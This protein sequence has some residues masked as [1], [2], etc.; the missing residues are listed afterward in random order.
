MLAANDRKDM[1]LGFIPVI[2]EAGRITLEVR[3]GGMRVDSKADDSPVSEADLRSQAHIAEGLARLCPDI[4]VLS[5]EGDHDLGQIG[6]RYFLVDPLDGTKEFVSGRADFAINIA[7]IEDGRPTVGLLYAPARKYLYLSWG[8]RT[9]VGK[10][11]G[12]KDLA[13]LPIHPVKPRPPVVLT[14]RS[15]LDADTKAFLAKL[16]EHT[17]HPMGSALK[18]GLV[19]DG[20][21]D[22]YPRF[23]P[24]MLWDV[25]AGQAVIEAAGGVVVGLDGTPLRYDPRRNLRN[26]SFIAARTPEAASQALRTMGASLQ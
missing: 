17:P 8:P 13:P 4:P 9:A 23:G 11:T 18:F 6:S 5:E 10:R 26:P 24:T 20:E 12:E 1:A 3:E 2:E 16:G 7:L 21:A 19:A 25:A 22:L 15:H 14:S